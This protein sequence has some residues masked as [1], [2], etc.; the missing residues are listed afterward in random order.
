MHLRA[1]RPPP[2]IQMAQEVTDNAEDAKREVDRDFQPSWRLFLPPKREP[3]RRVGLN[4]R[5]ERDTQSQV[6][7]DL[8]NRGHGVFEHHCTRVYGRSP[9]GFRPVS[10]A[11]RPHRTEGHVHAGRGIADEPPLPVVLGGE[12]GF[13]ISSSGF[14]KPLTSLRKSR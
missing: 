5:E 7:H 13:E 2:N 14:G 8:N 11:S 10:I 12:L 4:G 3:L 6:V 1:P 9:G